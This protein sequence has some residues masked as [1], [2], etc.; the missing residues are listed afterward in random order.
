M[1]RFWIEGSAGPGEEV[2]LS[3]EDVR[4]ADRVL[5]MRPGDACELLGGGAR[6]LGEI[7]ALSG[8]EGRV[9]VVRALPS[10][11]A[12]LR[13][14]LFQGL[15]K[16]DKIELIVQKAVELGADSVVPVVMPRSVSRLDPGDAARKRDRWQKIA[17]E[18]C[19]QSGRC[20]MP[21]VGT[22]IDAKRLPEA[23][24]GFD[25][26]IV[27]WE[28]ARSLSLKR[29]AA[30]HPDLRDL[31]VVIGPEGGMG[32]DEIADMRA[33]GCMPVTLGPRILRTETAGP[34]ALAVLMALYDEMEAVPCPE[35]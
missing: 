4:H 24:K 32:E 25:A 7:T 19:K 23:L 26:A 15:P 20:R 31:A 17:A 21:E 29:F 35:A 28:D 9:R 5:R 14:T 6:L 1:H 18:A 30:D 3:P 8:T 34:A 22:P 16:G 12:R 13:I 2:S 10:T 11:E 33:V 27:P